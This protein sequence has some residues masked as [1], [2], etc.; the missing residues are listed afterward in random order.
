LTQDDPPKPTGP[1]FGTRIPVKLRVMLRDDHDV[2]DAF[3]GDLGPTGIV[4]KTDRPVQEGAILSLQLSIKGSE[5][6]STE[7]EVIFRREPS[8]GQL[9]LGLRFL[10]WPVDRQQ[11]IEE[12][13]T[14]AWRSKARSALV[15]CAPGEQRD[16]L[17]ALLM[18]H[19]IRV[20]TAS[21][22]PQALKKL[23]DLSG[24][25]LIVVDLLFPPADGLDLVR[26][27]RLRPAIL[28]RCLPVMVLMDGAVSPPEVDRLRAE[29]ATA[30]VRY[31]RPEDLPM[32]ADAAMRLIG[33]PASQPGR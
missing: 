25:G 19:G 13:V 3:G 11:V 33:Q 20:L 23:R 1:Q 14:S 28:A 10:N 21:D 27:L 18:K 30:V 22:S 2:L 7:A 5:P 24:I 6:L 32:V 29:G 16:R 15:A 31:G 8:H 17:A 4:L 26:T 9:S 12:Q